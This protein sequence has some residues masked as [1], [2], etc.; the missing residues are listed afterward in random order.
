MYMHLFVPVFLYIS[1][2]VGCTIYIIIII[3]EETS[4]THVK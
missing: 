3:I 1:M 4:E 2:V